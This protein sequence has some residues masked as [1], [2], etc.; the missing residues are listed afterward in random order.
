M[1]AAK[2][3]LAEEQ[4]WVLGEGGKEGKY[5]GAARACSSSCEASSCSTRMVFSCFF[6]TSEM[7]VLKVV[8]CSRDSAR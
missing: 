8:V 5:E 2:G 1:E 4:R 3:K 7:R 6:A